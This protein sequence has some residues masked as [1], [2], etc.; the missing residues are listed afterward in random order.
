[1]IFNKARLTV[2]SGIAVATL[3]GTLL[4]PLRAQDDTRTRR[5][6]LQACRARVEKV[7]AGMQRWASEG[8]SPHKV[9]LIMRDEFFPHMQAGRFREAEKVAD[10]ILGILGKEAPMQKQKDMKAFL[11][12]TEETQYLILPVREAGHLYGGR[13]EA[14]E[15]AIQRT[16]K[17]IGRAKDPKKRNWG[18]HLIIPA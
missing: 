12:T 7:K 4:C 9:G 3:L 5:E 14:F 1:M 17:K 2:V 15:R 13:T 18:F 16:V 8:R 11:R 10:R 6:L